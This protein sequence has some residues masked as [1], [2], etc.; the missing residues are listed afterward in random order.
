MLL[1]VVPPQHFELPPG[2]SALLAFEAA[3]PPPFCPAELVVDVNLAA[4]L[5]E[6]SAQNAVASPPPFASLAECIGVDS[7]TDVAA[8][9]L[10]VTQQFDGAPAVRVGSAAPDIWAGTASEIGVASPNLSLPVDMSIQPGR[11]D[12]L[13]TAEQEDYRPLLRRLAIGAAGVKAEQD[14]LARDAASPCTYSSSS[15]AMS[16]A[17]KENGRNRAALS[18]RM[19][20][21]DP[22]TLSAVERKRQQNTL[23]A[24]RCRARKERRVKDLET[25]NAIL[26]RRVKEMK[27]VL[28]AAG[29]ID[30]LSAY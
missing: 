5:A 17:T 7:H 11:P 3:P 13:P 22:D 18:I 24:R 23:S 21:P 1:L 9:D 28:V 8:C 19:D 12:A 29:L 20:A 16:P 10:A 6:L 15:E 26:Q 25:E 2:P 4:F 30:H 14:V 27:E